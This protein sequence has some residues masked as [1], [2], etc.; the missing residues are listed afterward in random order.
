MHFSETQDRLTLKFSIVL[1][2]TVGCYICF[3]LLTRKTAMQDEYLGFNN[4]LNLFPEF[5]IA[6]PPDKSSH[7][8]PCYF[9]SVLCQM[10]GISFDPSNKEGMLEVSGKRHLVT[11][12]MEAF[13]SEVTH[14]VLGF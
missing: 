11:I 5:P 8:F 9:V 13:D 14:R 7:N 12:H 1:G 6:I 3:I 2:R 10:D 4:A